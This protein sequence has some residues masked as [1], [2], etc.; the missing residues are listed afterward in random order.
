MLP[1]EELLVLALTVDV[2]KERPDGAYL[3]RGTKLTVHPHAA[4]AAADA[5]G[6]HE[7]P[8]LREDLQ[9]LQ[10]LQRLR[11]ADGKGQLRQGVGRVL[12][13][14]APGD[15]AAQ[16]HRDRINNNRFASACL[17]GEDI[18]AI[19]KADVHLPDQSK[20]P[21]GKVF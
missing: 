21:D 13:D 18:Q 9:P 12:A 19:R 17:A 11:V 1:G 3:L 4:P 2:E 10:G 16:R 6:K 5:P 14:K 7:L 20:I 15:L 8:A